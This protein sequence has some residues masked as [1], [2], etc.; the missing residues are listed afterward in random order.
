M[1]LFEFL[2]QITFSPNL[3]TTRVF[4]ENILT[5]SVSSICKL[6]CPRSQINLIIARS[7]SLFFCQQSAVQFL[8]DFDA[9]N[10]KMT[11][12]YLVV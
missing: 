5:F 2:L 1:S 3:K 9:I 7:T 6:V 11:K 10:Q 8:F 12:N 4:N